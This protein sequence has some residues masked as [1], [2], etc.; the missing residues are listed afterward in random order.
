MSLPRCS[1]ERCSLRCTTDAG[2]F[3][4]YTSHQS[5]TRGH[6]YERTVHDRC[7]SRSGVSTKALTGGRPRPMLMTAF[8]IVTGAQKR[9]YA[10]PAAVLAPSLMSAEL[11]LA[12]LAK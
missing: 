9:S 12:L 2:P 7:R 10:K 4:V 8:G 1:T 11:L 3:P 5:H 6:S